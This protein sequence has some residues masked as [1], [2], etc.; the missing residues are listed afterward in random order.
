MALTPYLAH[1]PRLQPS[2]LPQRSPYSISL[3]ASCCLCMRFY[4]LYRSQVKVEH[5]LRVKGYRHGADTVTSIFK[6]PRLLFLCA[7]VTVRAFIIDCMS[8]N[9]LRCS[10][11]QIDALAISTCSVCWNGNKLP[12]HHN[13]II[14]PV[15]CYDK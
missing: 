9:I 2:R 10:S 15:A 7:C 11:T 13:M 12:I 4:L 5:N 8:A 1:K 14:H 6:M 3:P